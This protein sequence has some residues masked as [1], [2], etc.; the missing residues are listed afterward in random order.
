MSLACANNEFLKDIQNRCNNVGHIY[1]H[2]SGNCYYWNICAKKDIEYF[3]N[4]IYSDDA[5][6]CLLRKRNV[7]ESILNKTETKNVS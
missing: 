5:Q 1:S 7:F 4:F 3:Y 6:F 2:T